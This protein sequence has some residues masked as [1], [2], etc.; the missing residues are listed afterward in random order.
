MT[1]SFLKMNGLGNDFVVIDTRSGVA[2]PNAEQIS[3]IAD[4]R[5][6]VGCDQL[7]VME[8]AEA[9]AD[10]FI[11]I[12]NPDGSEAEA[13]G[14]AT[15]CV[16]RLVG[17][18]QGRD[19]IT[20]RTV[21]GLLPTQLRDDGRVTVDMGEPRFGWRDIPLAEAADTL[22]LD[23]RIG[24]IDAPELA[25]PC[26]VNMGNPHCIFFVDAVSAHRLEELG[27]LIE[28]HPL[29]PQR[30]N[31]GLAEMSAP[32]RL[33][34]RVWERGTGITPA[35][36]SGA[37]AAA[38]AAVRRGLAERRMTIELDGGELT[39]EWAGNNHVLMT[40]PTAFSFRGTLDECLTGPEA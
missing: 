19:A 6:G 11:R 40:G 21:A 20:V 12:F 18:E 37:C 3:R 4:R 16:A 10:I 25:R 17:T 15:R 27:P 38:V 1:T 30:T 35:C 13:C 8:P 33:R 14:N 24:P 9:P 31:V 22:Y 2:R 26:A 7:I 29:F 32:D 36:G 34:L 28:H 5:L 39:L 23:I